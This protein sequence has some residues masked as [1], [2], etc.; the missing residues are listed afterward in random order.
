MIHEN[1]TTPNPLSDG[2]TGCGHAAD[3]APMRAWT[4]GGCG[5]T[6]RGPRSV[7]P[8]QKAKA[9]SLAIRLF[10][11]PHGSR[12]DSLTRENC[13]ACA[14]RGYGAFE[15]GSDG[16]AR[17]NYAGWEVVYTEAGRRVPIDWY[18]AFSESFDGASAYSKAL[19]RAVREHGSPRKEA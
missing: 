12:T 17:P 8:P 10:C 19:R 18:T 14:L 11:C 9:R 16:P 15:E 5:V 1:D 13:G 2:C 3:V 6:Y 7:L 4:C